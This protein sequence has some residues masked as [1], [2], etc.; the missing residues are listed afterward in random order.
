MIGTISL[1]DQISHWLQEQM[2]NGKIKSGQKLSLA[3]LSRDIE[4][5]VTP[6]REALVQLVRTGIVRNISNRGFYIPQLSS[7]EAKSIYPAIYALE[8]LAIE[9]SQISYS[10]ITTLASIQ[11][12]FEKAPT[13]EDAVRLDLQFHNSLTCSYENEVIHNIL[14]DLKVRVFFYELKYMENSKN[15]QK[16]V[17][18]HYSI[19]QALIDKNIKKTTSLLQKNWETSAKFIEKLYQ[20]EYA[21]KTKKND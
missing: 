5:S 12:E 8:K 11:S 16:S 4:V 20:S 10:Q 14:N 19:L 13:R 9:Q 21:P 18:A 7:K 6:I 3:E 1:R 2:L 17:E 15:H